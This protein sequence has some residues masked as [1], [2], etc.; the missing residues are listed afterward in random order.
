MSPKSLISDALPKSLIIQHRKREIPMNTQRTSGGSVTKAL[1]KRLYRLIDKDGN[2]AGAG[3]ELR[4][5]VRQAKECWPDQAQDEERSGKGWDIEVCEYSP[6]LGKT[7]RT[8]DKLAA[9]LPL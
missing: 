9:E 3:Y 2:V 5:L 6:D 7:M 4:W 8:R 1:P